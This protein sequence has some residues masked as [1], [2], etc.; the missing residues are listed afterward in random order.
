MRWRSLGR[1]NDCFDEIHPPGC[2]F[3]FLKLG[4]LADIVV[5]AVGVGK[6]GVVDFLLEFLEGGLEL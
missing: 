1:G 3:F 2:Y 4:E 6:A 5:L